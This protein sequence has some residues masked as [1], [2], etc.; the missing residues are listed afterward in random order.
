MLIEECIFWAL[1][2]ESY[3]NSGGL[4]KDNFL[5]AVHLVTLMHCGEVVQMADGVMPN[6]SEHGSAREQ[7]IAKEFHVREGLRAW[8]RDT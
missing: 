2:S 1:P 7:S 6:I 5:N 4:S 8:G 3:Y